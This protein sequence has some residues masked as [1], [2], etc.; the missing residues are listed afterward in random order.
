MVTE[1]KAGMTNQAS[2]GQDAGTLR[3]YGRETSERVRTD[4]LYSSISS[5]ERTPKSAMVTNT[6]MLSD[7]KEVRWDNWRIAIEL[8]LDLNADWYPTE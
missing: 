5:I 7:G 4:G 3:N 6:P 1:A 2:A 8:K